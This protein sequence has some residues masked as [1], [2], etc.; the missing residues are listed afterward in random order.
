MKLTEFNK[1]NLKTMRAEID[2]ALATVAEKYGISMSIGGIRYDADGSNFHTKL[3]AAIIGDGGVTLDGRAKDFQL[4]AHLFGLSA[5][6][7]GRQFTSGSKSMTIT[8]FNTRARKAPFLAKCRED[9]KTYRYEADYLKMLLKI[10]E[11]KKAS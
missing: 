8:G 2:A 5:D 3:E 9:G 11:E 7:L 10:Q 6:D 1:T 4:N